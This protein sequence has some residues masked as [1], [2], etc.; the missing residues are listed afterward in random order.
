LRVEWAGYDPQP[1]L[2]EL[3]DN[4][5]EL[6]PHESR[7]LELE[8]RNSKVGGRAKGALIVKAANSTETRLAF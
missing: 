6:M 7:D 3:N 4:D 2:S 1:Y 8:W 5:F